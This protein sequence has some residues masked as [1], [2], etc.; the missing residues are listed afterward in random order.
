MAQCKYCGEKDE[1]KLTMSTRV[2][3]GKVETIDVC[4][5]CFW[6]E[7]SR[8]EGKD[9]NKLSEQASERADESIRDTDPFVLPERLRYKR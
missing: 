7:K 9:G 3:N 6:I 4:L 2:V 1:S 8:A 5:A